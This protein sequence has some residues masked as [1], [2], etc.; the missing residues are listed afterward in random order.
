MPDTRRCRLLI[1][2]TAVLLLATGCGKHTKPSEQEPASS[3]SQLQS[4][5]PSQEICATDHADGDQ[6]LTCRDEQD[7]RKSELGRAACARLQPGKTTTKMVRR[8]VPANSP[9][10]ANTSKKLIKT[11]KKSPKAT[12]ETRM[13]T[14]KKLVRISG[15][16]QPQCVIYA[17]CRSGISTCRLGDTNPVQWIACATKHGG[18]S[19]L[20]HIG[21]VMVLTVN[22]GGHRM[23]S[24]HA[25]YVEDAKKLDNGTWQL[26]ISHTN[27]DRKC[28]LDL[29]ATVLF[30]PQ[31]MTVSFKTGAWAHWATDLKILGFILR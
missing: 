28:H 3:E 25:L 6:P 4:A 19:S 8:Q 18:A 23:P 21:S 22:A 16:C 20:P 9:Q 15:R 17:R 13:T 26:R 27:Y 12:A 10:N 1:L 29:D 30:D 31:R 5:A 7:I 14:H 11:A 2:L 24:G